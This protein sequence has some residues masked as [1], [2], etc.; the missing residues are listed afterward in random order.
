MGI[1][2]T[3]TQEE[4]PLKY[5]HYTLKETQDGVSHSVYLLEDMYVLKIVTLEE[6]NALENEQKLL[7]ELQNI[8]VPKLLD[9]V[10]KTDF[11]LAFY[12]QVEGISNAHPQVIHIKEIALF[13][14]KFH[15]LSKDLNSSNTQIYTKKHLKILILQTK[16]E[17]LVNHFNTL[18][19]EL[20]NDGIIHGDLFYDNAK[21]QGDK[22]SGVYDFTEACEGDFVFELA[23]VA[24]SWCFE[25]E[26]LNSQKVNHLLQN[27]GTD[28]QYEDFKEYIKYALLYYTTTRYLANQN[29]QE[30]L[31]K[32]EQL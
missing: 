31:D 10:Q 30:L 14:K 9:I 28:I 21:F 32:L 22:L 25:S 16:N 15:T 4:L 18:T 2:Q 12:T 29:Y 23:V 11:I 5:R 8:C 27:Y 13:L 7:N 19:C 24:L 1:K 3:I 20:Q 6:L 17:I 26:N